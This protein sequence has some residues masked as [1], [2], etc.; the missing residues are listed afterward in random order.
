MTDRILK[1]MAL[2]YHRIHDL[3]LKSVDRLDD[4]Q[5]IWRMNRTTPSVAFY[6][7]H[8]ARW[9]DYLQEGLTDDGHQIWVTEELVA[10]W[11]FNENLGY[12][13]TGMGMD[14]DVS[15]SLPMPSR[16]VLLDYVTRAFDKAEKAVNEINAEAFYYKFQDRHGVDS[17]YED[18]FSSLTIGQAVLECLLHDVQHLGMIE[19]LLGVMGMR[20]TAGV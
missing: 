5:L 14:D 15:A 1:N 13:D 9:A 4:Q 2:R 6:V 18:Y 16:D 3:V 8:L 17:E 11:G 10:K 7:W 19:C 20:G 12:A